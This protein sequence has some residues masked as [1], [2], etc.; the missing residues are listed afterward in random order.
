MREFDI[1]LHCFDLSNAKGLE[2][3]IEMVQ[4]ES[5]S[6]KRKYMDARCASLLIGCKSDLPQAVPDSAIQQ[7]MQLYSNMFREYFPVSSVTMHSVEKLRD[8][9]IKRISHAYF[10]K[11][12]KMQ[13]QPQSTSMCNLM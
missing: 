13:A 12:P 7:A 3:L 1:A 2:E 8:L 5:C 6:G 10:V 9:L 4:D 11:F